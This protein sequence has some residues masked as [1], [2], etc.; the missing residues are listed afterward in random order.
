M[1]GLSEA[2]SISHS[3]LAADQMVAGTCLHRPR[4]AGEQLQLPTPVSAMMVGTPS[5]LSTNAAVSCTSSRE[6]QAH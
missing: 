3:L 1:A 5:H 4:Q 6:V 2:G